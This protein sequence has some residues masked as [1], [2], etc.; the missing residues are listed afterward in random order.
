MLVLQGEVPILNPAH[1]CDARKFMMLNK[2][3]A[4]VEKIS[5]AVLRANFTGKVLIMIGTLFS[6]LLQL[7]SMCHILTMVFLDKLFLVLNI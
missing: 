4:Y 1:P 3:S 5:D 7:F 2:E 6:S